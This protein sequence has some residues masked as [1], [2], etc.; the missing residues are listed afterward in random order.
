MKTP[1][2]KISELDKAKVEEA[3]ASEREEIK[4]LRKAVAAE[5]RELKKLARAR[6]REELKEL[7]RLDR[8][9]QREQAKAT[10]SKNQPRRN[11]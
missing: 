8:A 1:R 4:T 6:E 11:R 10:G 7:K 9:R 3:K 5:H 2:R